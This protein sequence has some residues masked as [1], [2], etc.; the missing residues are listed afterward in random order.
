MARRSRLQQAYDT[1]LSGFEEAIAAADEPSRL[2]TRH[3]ARKIT[4]PGPPRRPARR[5]LPPGLGEQFAGTVEGERTKASLLGDT[6]AIA[7]RQTTG[8]TQRA[9]ASDLE[10]DFD[11]IPFAST[12]VAEAGYNP[13]LQVIRVRFADG[14]P[15]EYRDVPEE[16]WTDFKTSESAGRF[17]YDVL[18][19]YPYGRGRF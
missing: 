10:A 9:I 3:L 1:A 18:D 8:I 15:W 5:L 13:D 2:P 6:R 19:S 11:M 4:P 12:R 7:A 16:V 14:T 17:I